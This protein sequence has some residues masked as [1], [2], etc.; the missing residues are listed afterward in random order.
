MESITHSIPL[1]VPSSLSPLSQ[2]LDR[3]KITKDLERNAAPFYING[4]HSIPSS[5]KFDELDKVD[6]VPG[7]DCFQIKP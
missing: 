6:E 5:N 7:A 3:L 2:I 1:L 4:E